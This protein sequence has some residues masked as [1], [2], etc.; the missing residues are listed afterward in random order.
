MP[1]NLFNQTVKSLFTLNW[2]FNVFPSSHSSSSLHPVA[3]CI[4]HPYGAEFH[5]KEIFVR[6]MVLW[7]HVHNF[8]L[9]Y[10]SNVTCLYFHCAS[11]TWVRTAVNTHNLRL[12]S[13]KVAE[14]APHSRWPTY[15]WSTWRYTCLVNQSV[16]SNMGEFTMEQA[17]LSTAWIKQSLVTVR[18]RVGRKE[19]WN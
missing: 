11:Y 6:V 15:A 7:G 13:V 2:C 16:H 19:G 10:E 17:L 9:I 12:W 5:C 14:R 18:K 3:A 4:I 1:Y 8:I